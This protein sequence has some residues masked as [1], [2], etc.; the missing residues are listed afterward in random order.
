LLAWLIGRSVGWLV[1]CLLACLFAWLVGCLV[2]R[3]FGCLVVWLI[4][5]S[6][7]RIVFCLFARC[8][9][10]LPYAV[11]T[12]TDQSLTTH[13]LSTTYICTHHIHTHIINTKS[14]NKALMYS[15]LAIIAA[16]G[17]GDISSHMKCSTKHR[18]CD[19]LFSCLFSS[20]LYIPTDF[21]RFPFCNLSTI[22]FP[23]SRVPYIPPVSFVSA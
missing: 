7:A 2:G 1:G 16:S 17:N 15:L 19:V 9:H 18:V 3:L 8:V 6:V 20:P 5:R 10:A 11:L 12:R 21:L 13:K 14:S 22:F 4:G 23:F